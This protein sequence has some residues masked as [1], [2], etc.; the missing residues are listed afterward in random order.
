MIE[1][2]FERSTVIG[3][4]VIGGVLSLVASWSQ[5]RGWVTE[6]QHNS[7][8]KAAYGFMAASILLF[9]A[10]DLRKP[11]LKYQPT[12]GLQRLLEVM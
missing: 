9:Y 11:G 5:S 4:A 12:V 7:L 8:N 10:S 2:L 3:F 1:T 6:Q